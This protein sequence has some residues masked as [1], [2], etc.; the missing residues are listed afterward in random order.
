MRKM[1]SHNGVRDGVRSVGFKPNIKRTAGNT[2]RVTAGGV[3]RNSNQIA[4]SVIAASRIQGEAK[5]I[6][7]RPIICGARQWRG[8]TQPMLNAVE[9][10]CG[11]W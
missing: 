7:P 10:L 3:M 2:T 6:A 4:G 8:V 5:E 11:V 1:T 9:H